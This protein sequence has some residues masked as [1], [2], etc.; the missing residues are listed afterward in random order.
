MKIK[1][2]NNTKMPKCGR[3]GDAGYDLYLNSIQLL[4]RELMLLIQVFV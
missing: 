2:L 1:L 3:D 4:N